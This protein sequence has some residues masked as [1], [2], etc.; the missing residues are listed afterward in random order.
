VGDGGDAVREVLVVDDDLAVTDHDGN[1]AGGGAPHMRDERSG[2]R[3]P[4]RSG[5]VSRRCREYDGRAGGGSAGTG[6]DEEGS[7]GRISHGGHPSA[8]GTGT[9]GI[10]HSHATVGSDHSDR[11]ILRNS[12]SALVRDESNVARR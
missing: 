3:R 4:L 6:E 8:T 5:S 11:R 9:S 10:L 1:L 12:R 7:T 2:M